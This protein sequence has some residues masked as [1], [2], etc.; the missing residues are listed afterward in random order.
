[1]LG[2]QRMRIA[3]LLL[4]AVPLLGQGKLDVIP[5]PLVTPSAIEPGTL[6]PPLTSKEKAARAFRQTL[7][8]NSLLNRT[9]V[10]G[11]DQL[12]DSPHEWP[13][14]MEGYGMRYGSRLGRLAIR[15]T[16]ML[17]TDV[18]FKLDP[19]Y[20]RCAC[21]G[22]WPR[23]KHAYKRVLVARTDAG[24]HMFNV[25]R[26]A[27]GFLTPMIANEWAPDRLNTWGNKFQDGGTY[28]AW[29]GAGNVLREFW[30]DIRRV[31]PFKKKP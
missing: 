20:D 21:T 19:R 2:R 10:A 23:V 4:S 24:G 26:F 7:G 22:V 30:P 27:G 12:R 11:W 8:I 17:G 15:N 29:N 3:A 9:I 14:G 28:L 13:G 1:M 18:A 31:L 6:P 5:L 16:I 25:S